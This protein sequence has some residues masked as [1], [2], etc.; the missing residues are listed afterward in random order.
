MMGVL[1]SLLLVLAAQ[2]QSFA[3]SHSTLTPFA[4]NK[5][6]WKNARNWRSVPAADFSASTATPLIEPANGRLN[7]KDFGA[8]GD[9][10]ADDTA[11]L[12]KAIDAAQSQ[13]K[14]LFV[15]GGSYAVSKPLFIHCCNKWC[16]HG[17]SENVTYRGLS[18]VGAGQFL[19]HFFAKADAPRL[20][21]MLHFESHAL[22][23]F[24]PDPGHLNPDHL[25]PGPGSFKGQ[26]HYN[27]SV[28]HHLADFHLSGGAQE[29]WQRDLP[30]WCG[31]GSADPAH[32]GADYGVYG[33]GLTWSLF[34]RL[35]ISFVR[36]AAVRLFYCWYNRVED[37]DFNQAQ[38]GLHSACNNM[39]ITGSN[40][41][42]MQ[43]AAVLIDG[44][45]AIDIDGNLLEGNG[46][47]AIILSGG[48]WGAPQGVTITSNYYE[49]NNLEPGHWRGSDGNVT[50]CTDLLLTGHP[51]NESFVSDGRADRIGVLGADFPV[52]GVTY[53]G[54]THDPPS[55]AAVP[56]C[57][58]YAGITAVA[59]V[60]LTALDNTMTDVLPSMPSKNGVLLRTGTDSAGWMASDVNLIGNM[61]VPPYHQNFENYGWWPLIDLVHANRSLHGPADPRGCHGC[62][63]ELPLHTFHAPELAQ[64]N[65]YAAD[66]GWHDLATAEPIALVRHRRGY[67]RL[68]S[69]TWAVDPAA[70]RRAALVA[71]FELA[72]TPSLAGR[73]TYFAL[74]WRPVANGSS[75][76][77]LIDDGGGS[78]QVSNA[79]GLVCNSH[80][81]G[82]CMVSGANPAIAGEWRTRVFSAT[83]RLAGMARFA[84]AVGVPAADGGPT[85]SGVVIA[86]VGARYEAVAT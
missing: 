70:G 37:C 35:Q 54:N 4:R 42:S 75:L 48:I 1:V 27:G 10:A 76:S 18:M 44:G 2:A 33:P 25:Q 43:L 79:T 71:S 50:L 77:L 74:K 81:V 20:S 59:V 56:G 3:T 28:E 30:A 61:N 41:N 26:P 29:G 6:A 36:V 13:G 53:T 15:P 69:V 58:A 31:G 32:C 21:S 62:R 47:P 49:A 24:T 11:A 68:E 66:D 85:I 73:A 12:Q 86:P 45:A 57:T 65:F 38:V 22:G 72:E 46:G 8:V 84:V 7:A 51:W 64:R 67:D 78:W 14:Q 55:T 19:T 83:M 40:I 17:F 23:P 39:R 80:D 16:Q 9:G 5:Q 52:L 60:G 34:Q 82:G 63:G